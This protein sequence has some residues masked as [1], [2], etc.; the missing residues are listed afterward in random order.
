MVSL[1]LVVCAATAI[2]TL[3]IFVTVTRLAAAGH[4]DALAAV[5]PGMLPPMALVFG[6]LVGFLAA[7]VWSSSSSAQGAVNNEAGALRSVDLLDREFA[8]ADH[9]RMDALIRAYIQ[10]VVTREW[11][12]MSHQNA[13]LLVA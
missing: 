12:A 1:V 13:T 7:E 4:S 9:Q 8:A 6:L 5:S 3:A 11:P 2:V 10:Q